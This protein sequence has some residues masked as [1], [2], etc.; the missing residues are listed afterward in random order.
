MNRTTWLA[1]CA[2][3][4]HGPG[5]CA[6]PEPQASTTGAESRHERVRRAIELPPGPSIDD[7]RGR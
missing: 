4:I 6:E 7:A 3:A 1:A 5:L 2:L